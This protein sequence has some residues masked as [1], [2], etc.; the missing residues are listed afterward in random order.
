MRFG[1]FAYKYECEGLID[2]KLEGADVGRSAKRMK[3]GKTE[4]EEEDEEEEEE[5]DD[6]EDNDDNDDYYDFLLPRFDGVIMDRHWERVNG[7][8]DKVAKFVI[9]TGDQEQ[10]EVMVDKN[11][12]EYCWY[13]IGDGEWKKCSVDEPEGEIN[14]HI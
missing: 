7:Q 2:Y 5:D 11:N 6:E 1:L 4:D 14:D 3:N 13:N 8:G 10:Q 9:K 12:T